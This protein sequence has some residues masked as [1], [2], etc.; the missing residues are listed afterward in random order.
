[1]SAHETS[2]T[3]LALADAGSVA[4]AVRPRWLARLRRVPPSLVLAWGIIAIVL[5]WAAAP[6]LFTAYSGTEGVPGEQLRAP[7]WEHVLGT[8]G[9]GRD[10]YAR[11]VHGAVHSLSGAFVAVTVGLLL[12]TLLGLVAGARGGW[13]DAVIMRLVDSML[14]VPSLL[15]SLSI[16]VLLGFGTIN[17][18]VAVGAVAVARFARLARSEVMRV[19][20][21]VSQ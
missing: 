21:G 2:E 4:A 7:D 20:R 19:R 8:D 15:L 6:T 5:L 10:V 9:L 18:A 16:I 11:I 17:V 1:M 12:G 14:A 13:T 3:D